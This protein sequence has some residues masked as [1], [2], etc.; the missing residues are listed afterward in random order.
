MKWLLV[1]TCLAFATTSS[2]KPKSKPPAKPGVIKGW[3]GVW[4]VEHPSTN[5]EGGG[6]LC[7]GEGVRERVSSES[8]KPDPN[9]SMY[10]VKGSVLKFDVLWHDYEEDPD[11]SVNGR[12]VYHVSVKLKDISKKQAANEMGNSIAGTRADEWM[13][14]DPPLKINRGRGSKTIDKMHIEVSLYNVGDSG[15]PE[16]SGRLGTVQITGG[17]ANTGFACGSTIHNVAGYTEVDFSK[18]H[19]CKQTT[20]SCTAD[21]Q[22]CSKSCSSDHHETGTCN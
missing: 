18:G 14:L 13:K 9:T 5:P 20:R 16:A 2:A 15:G 17:D 21:D 22:C 10:G 6:L 11:G 12:Q 3:N 8:P 7:P 1:L 19:W 4:E